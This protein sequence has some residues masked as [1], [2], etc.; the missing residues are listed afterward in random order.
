MRSDS[1]A[2]SN[3]SR[4]APAPLRGGRRR[5]GGDQGSRAYDNAHYDDDATGVTHTAH[6]AL[7]PKR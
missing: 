1:K 4:R 6:T 5:K 3:S 2:P 7:I